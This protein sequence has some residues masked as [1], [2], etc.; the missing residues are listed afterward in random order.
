MLRAQKQKDE[1]ENQKQIEEEQRKQLVKF[2]K[3]WL[4]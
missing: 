1:E 4:W 3:F 2:F